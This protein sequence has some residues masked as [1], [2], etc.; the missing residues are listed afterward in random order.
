MTEAAWDQVDV[1][2]PKGCLLCGTPTRSHSLSV[3]VDETV[4]GLVPAGSREAADSIV[5][6]C[7]S[8]YADLDGSATRAVLATRASDTDT[9]DEV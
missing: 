4:E 9:E 1:P 7:H 2:A 8:C 3:S 5:A 6:V